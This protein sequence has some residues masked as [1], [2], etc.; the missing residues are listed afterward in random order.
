MINYSYSIISTYLMIILASYNVVTNYLFQS[1]YWPPLGL[2][3][4]ISI[5]YIN[6]PLNRLSYYCRKKHIPY[7]SIRLSIPLSI[8]S[9]YILSIQSLLELTFNIATTGINPFHT[10]ILI[11]SIILLGSTVGICK[12]VIDS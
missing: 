11:I 3:I 8:I 1:Y 2:A 7:M 9:V 10:P 4:V 6:I 5:I 12:Q